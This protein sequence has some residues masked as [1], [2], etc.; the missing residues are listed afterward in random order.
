[1][2][3]IFSLEL[4]GKNK[5]RENASY[6]GRRATSRII[7]QTRPN[8]KRGAKERHLQVSKL[9]M[10]LQAKIILQRFVV[11]ALHHTLHVITQMP[12]GKR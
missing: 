5:E 4:T 8:P 2:S 11:T 1:M 12:Y 10:I 7:A 3:K 6:V 9:G